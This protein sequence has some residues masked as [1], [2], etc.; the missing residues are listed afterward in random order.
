M[1]GVLGDD[2]VE[3]R[4]GDPAPDPAGAG[5]P[6]AEYSSLERS[7]EPEQGT[8]AGRHRHR[9]ARRLLLPVVVGAVSL[10]IVVAAF[11]L[12]LAGGTSAPQPASVPTAT[13]TGDGDSPTGDAAAVDP[14][15]PAPAVLRREG[16]DALLERRADAMLRRDEQAWLAT[17]SSAAPDFTRRQAETFANLADVPLVAWGYEYAGAGP[18]LPDRRRDAL[19]PDATTVRVVLAYR[20]A[21]AD[22]G[23]VRREQT[24]TL[25]RSGD[26]WLVADDRDGRTATDLWDMGPVS[27]ARGTRTLVLGTVPAADLQRYVTETDAAAAQ[28]DRVWGTGWPRTAVVQVPRDQEEMARLL[29]RDDP[30]GLEQVAAVTTGELG[31]EP[32]GARANRVVVN[33]GGFAQLGPLGRSVVLAHELTHVATRASSAGDVPVWLSEGFADLVAYSGTDLPRRIVADDV[34]QDVR[35][36][37]AP[38]DLPGPA[39]FDPTDGDIAPAYS[40]SWLAV[41]LLQRRHGMAAVVELYR[42]VSAGRSVDAALRIGMGTDVETFRQDWLAYLHD[43]AGHERT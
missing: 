43:L 30:G 32:D 3:P 39:D 4:D 35:E 16:L 23:D 6:P 7:A 10:A 28:V 22:T 34:L 24:L 26:G 15:R 5:E 13:G 31:L 1:V 29:L 42:Q 41:D 33:P 37:D 25:T 12:A 19:G 21:G 27:V 17:V 14:A 40:G 2:G 36:G 18:P 20:L 8:Q 9:T 38:S 11:V